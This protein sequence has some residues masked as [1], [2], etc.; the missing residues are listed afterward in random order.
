MGRGPCLL[1]PLLLLAASTPAAE[2]VS[3]PRL[4]EAQAFLVEYATLSQSQSP[5][6]FELYSDR[7]LIRTHM[8]GQ[9]NDT[10]FEGR[11]YKVWS[12]ELLMARRIGIDVSEFH[13]VM[14]EERGGRLLIRAKRFSRAR[15]FWDL[16]YQVALVRE[17]AGLKI[18]HERITTAPARDC[19]V[20]E[21]VRTADR[22]DEARMFPATASLSGWHPLSQE[23]VARSAMQL[24]QEM[25]AR[26]HDKPKSVPLASSSTAAP[27]VTRIADPDS[28]LITPG[29]D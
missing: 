28:V 13:E 26:N 9:A 25:A 3:E 17:A 27:V 24:A 16:D 7:A 8:E 21:G 14:V 12:R 18:V 11:A 4:L 6:F 22:G 1:L 15:C 23:E 5:D 20:T 29:E 19:P 10:A 2:P